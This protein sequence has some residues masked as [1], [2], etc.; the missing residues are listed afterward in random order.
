MSTYLKQY[1]RCQ[2][3]LS[4]LIRYRDEGV[5]YR[6]PADMSVEELASYGVT[7]EDRDLLVPFFAH[8]PVKDL[9]KAQIQDLEARMPNFLKALSN[10]SHE[11]EDA[12]YAFF[13]DCYHLKDWI[14]NDPGCSHR[15]IVESFVSGSKALSLCADICNSS[16]HLTLTRSR[17]GH[18]PK[19]G[20]HEASIRP[21]HAENRKMFYVAYKIEDGE[22]QVDTF[23][24]A[25]QCMVEWKSF[26]GL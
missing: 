3:R 5:P 16:K 14:K 1:A 18:N 20:G 19:L 22:H 6:D 7:E 9:T 11:C 25:E 4:A 17:S 2:R 21:V 26:L 12:A 23:D 15:G 13:Q 10:E 24:L 8:F